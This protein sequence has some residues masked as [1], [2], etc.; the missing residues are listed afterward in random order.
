VI[1]D[2]LADLANRLHEVGVRGAAAGRILEEAREHLYDDARDGKE[3]AIRRFG[4]AAELAGRIAA[5]LATT[6]TRRAVYGAFGALALAG[7]G[8]VFMFALLPLAGGSPDIFDGRVA[9]VGPL[10]GLA[11][12]L[13]PQIAFVSGC[14]ALVRAVR[15]RRAQL[16]TDAELRLLR[17]RG[18]VAIVATLG[19]LAAVAAYAVNFGEAQADWWTWTTVAACAVLAVPLAAATGTVRRSAAP[20]AA[21]G[22]NPGD[23]FD[24]LAPLFGFPL[25]RG[26]DLPSHPWRFAMLCAAAVGLVGLVG[27]T[28]AEGDPGSGLVRGGFE[29]VALL[30]CFA[31]LG[32]ILGLR[33]SRA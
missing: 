29:A 28:Y 32:R 12:G 4:P 25:L 17:R 8:Y 24:D 18:F 26:L 22:R 10:S 15:I 19:T 33:R 31:V 2:Y 16:V 23:V 27:G 21:P 6:Q 9:A 13:L 7:I 14:L 20:T 1:D 30:V 11:M 5:E 3:A